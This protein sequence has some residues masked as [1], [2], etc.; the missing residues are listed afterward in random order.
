MPYVEYGMM[1]PVK[2]SFTKHPSFM[3]WWNRV[4]ER[5][6]WRKVAGRG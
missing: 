5:P 2:D 4:S 3:A 6:S 1:T